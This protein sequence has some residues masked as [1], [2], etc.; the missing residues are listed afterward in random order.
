[1]QKYIYRGILLVVLVFVIVFC[2][3]Q[4]E[5][6]VIVDPANGN[7][8]KVDSIPRV[9]W[10]VGFNYPAYCENSHQYNLIGGEDQNGDFFDLYTV[11]AITGHTISHPSFP[12]YRQFLCMQYP[13]NNNTLY[14]VWRD[15]N[16]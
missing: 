8:S 5:Y 16:T 13:R 11:D 15:T 14:G 3:A 9:R 1:M 10:L 4:R 7:I 12:D 2:N 6:L